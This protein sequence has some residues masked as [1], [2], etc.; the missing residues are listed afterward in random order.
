MA[1]CMAAAACFCTRPDAC[2]ALTVWPPWLY[3]LPGAILLYVASR[4]KC[5]RNVLIVGIL[6]FVAYC[7]I[8]C[9][10]PRSLL[11]GPIR[12]YFASS[13]GDQRLRVVSLNC[14][15]GSMDAAEEVLSYQPDIVLL[16]E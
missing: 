4:K 5:P 15:A 6:F 7:L 10:E 8:F 3:L 11:F 16:Q 1:L 13:P 2:A 12:N 9:E 14:A